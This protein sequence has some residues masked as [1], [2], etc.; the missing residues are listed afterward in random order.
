MTEPVIITATLIILISIKL[1]LLLKLRKKDNANKTVRKL[2]KRIIFWRFTGLL[3]N[4]GLYIFTVFKINDLYKDNYKIIITV[5]LASLAF[6]ASGIL[7]YMGEK[8][9]LMRKGRKA[10]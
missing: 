2:K 6:L 7:F 9:I 1:K 5:I 3:L 10:E 8:S 4:T